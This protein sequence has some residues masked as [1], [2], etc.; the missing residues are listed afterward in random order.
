MRMRR[1]ALLAMAL[2]VVSGVLIGC[3]ARS[4]V[5]IGWRGSDSRKRTWASYVSFGGLERKSFRAEAGEMIELDYDVEVEEGALTIQLLDPEEDRVFHRTFRES[6]ADVELM[7]APRSG[8]YELRI[9][10]EGTKGSYDVS[11]SVGDSGS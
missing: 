3:G 4:S 11:W 7:S 10:G 2:L 8:R 6:A 1:A 9:E 5:K